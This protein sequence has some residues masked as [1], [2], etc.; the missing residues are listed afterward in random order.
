LFDICDNQFADLTGT[1][2]DITL[3][4]TVFFALLVSLC[5]ATE[6]Q[7]ACSICNLVVTYVEKY[8]EANQTEQ[9]IIT[10]LQAL[11][12]NF[13]P[14]QPE[15][16]S[17]VASYAPQIIAWVIAKEPPA[18]IC[19]QLRVCST[20]KLHARKH[21]QKHVEKRD[22]EQGACQICELIVT[23]VEQ[24]VAQ[25][26]T[27][28]EIEQK[29]DALCALIPSPGSGICQTLVNGYLPQIINWVIKKESPQTVCSQVKAC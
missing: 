26:N 2:F 9:E 10:Q 27:I 12:S 24:L 14:L 21:L 17:F 7:A 13:G 29:I 22:V 18:T 28:S 3:L 19:A 8:V 25:N 20:P 5:A 16:A 23:Y 6:E 1:L 4:L 11:C 15:C